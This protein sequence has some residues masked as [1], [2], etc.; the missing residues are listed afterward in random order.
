MRWQKALELLLNGAAWFRILSVLEMVACTA[1]LVW[2]QERT[3]ML[4]TSTGKRVYADSGLAHKMVVTHLYCYAAFIVIT[5][6]IVYGCR[7]YKDR[8]WVPD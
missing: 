8:Q 3:Q 4:T 6:I 5:P 2:S 7:W 1:A